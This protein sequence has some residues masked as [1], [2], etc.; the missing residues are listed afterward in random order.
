[1]LRA[2]N[3]TWLPR[4][5]APL[6][7]PCLMVPSPRAVGN[8]HVINQNQNIIRDPPLL[9]SR[10]VPASNEMLSRTLAKANCCIFD[11]AKQHLYIFEASSF[12]LPITVPP[13]VSH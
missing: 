13:H 7:V 2:A 5:R 6:L 4:A 10:G 11:G 1:M 12:V 8:D 3:L 9:V